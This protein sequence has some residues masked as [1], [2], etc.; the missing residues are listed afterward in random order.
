M[1]TAQVSQ[2]ELANA[3][4][5][6]AIDAVN[7]AKSAHPDFWHKYAGLTDAVIGV[8]R[9]DKS[10]PAAQVYELLDVTAS[11]LIAAV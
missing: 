11:K 10:A 3:I 6:L 1:Q 7:Q 8:A 5:F 9:F 2:R 4:R